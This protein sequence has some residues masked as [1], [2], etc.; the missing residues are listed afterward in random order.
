MKG[1]VIVFKEYDKRIQG[2][3]VSGRDLFKNNVA[4]IFDKNF[5]LPDYLKRKVDKI[6]MI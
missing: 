4:V 3:L 6:L 1:Y 2:L 5:K